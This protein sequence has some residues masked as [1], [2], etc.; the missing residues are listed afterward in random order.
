MANIRIPS[1]VINKCQ[2]VYTNSDEIAVCER[3]AMAGLAL[4][5]ILNA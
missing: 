2:M 1:D 4:G 5:N 3:S